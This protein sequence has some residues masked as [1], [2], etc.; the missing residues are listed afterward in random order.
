MPQSDC[1]VPSCSPKP[2]PSVLWDIAMYKAYHVLA[3]LVKFLVFFALVFSV[4]FLGLVL[5]SRDPEFALTILALPVTIIILL[6]A[7]WGIRHE[8]RPVMILFMIGLSLFI[9]YFLFKLVRMYEI[10][11]AYKYL[12]VRKYLTSFGNHLMHVSRESAYLVTE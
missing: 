6:L 4:Q 5:S 3:M 1:T 7:P 11:Q 9:T 10:S 8:N 2:H 12:N